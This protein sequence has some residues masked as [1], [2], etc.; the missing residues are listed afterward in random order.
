MLKQE[1]RLTLARPLPWLCMLAFVACLEGSSLPIWIIRC[2]QGDRALMSAM[3]LT[4]TPVFFGGI[5][6]LVPLCAAAAYGAVHAEEL[7]TRFFLFEM[8]R[9]SERKY[10]LT[11]ALSAML[12]GALVLG[13]GFLLHVILWHIV[14]GPYDVAAR[15]DIAVDFVTGTVY[16]TYI[17]TPYA[18]MAYVHAVLGFAAT[19]ALW[20]MIAVTLLVWNRDPQLSVALT[21]V[22]YYLMRNRFVELILGIRMPSYTG[23]YNDGQLWADYFQALGF[24][25]VLMAA[26]TAVYGWG[27]RRC[28][29]RG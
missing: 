20:A 16:D 26:L 2:Q 5:M 23:L 8:K 4:F 14:A 10:V 25:L 21:V 12:T 1:L 24:H 7:R 3:D 13:G 28:E 6:L 18:F 9:T 29:E 19:G 22:I 11:K 15:P 27:V 17:Q